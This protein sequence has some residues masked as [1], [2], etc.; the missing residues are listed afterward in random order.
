LI[1][2]DSSNSEA[3]RV[4]VG[5]WLPSPPMPTTLS[6]KRE[7]TELQH[8]LLLRWL[9]KMGG[10]PLGPS[11][12][13]TRGQTTQTDKPSPGALLRV[14]QGTDYVETDKAILSAPKILL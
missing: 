7:A 4:G 1:S 11:S 9:P 12:G 10:H 6:R 3:P 14:H 8:Q 2:H 13:Y 5:S